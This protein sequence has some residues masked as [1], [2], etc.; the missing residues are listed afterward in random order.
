MKKRRARR[1]RT[2]TKKFI[3]EGGFGFQVPPELEC[4]Q[5]YFNRKAYGYLA[6]DF[7]HEF[8]TKHWQTVTG[9][10]IRNWKS[11]ATEWIFDHQQDVKLILK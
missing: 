11:L 2:A 8:K 3:G 5:M 9:K 1:F 10:K 7:Y 6:T 4:V